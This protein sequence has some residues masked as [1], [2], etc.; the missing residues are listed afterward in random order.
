MILSAVHGGLFALTLIFT[1]P[2]PK[3]G[4][5]E[6]VYAVGSS[7]VAPLPPPPPPVSPS[8]IARGSWR[9][10]GWLAV[11]LH[12]T[13]PVAGMSPARPSLISLG[14]G[15]E[16]GWRIRQWLALGAAFGRQP[17]ELYR[18]YDPELLATFSYRGFMSA[19]DVAFVRVY[20]PIRGRF[21]PYID[22][23]GGLSFFNPARDR[24]NE[25]GATV[26]AGAGFDIWVSRTMT[27]GA[28]GI[29]RVNFIDTTVGQ[30]WQAALNIGL[31]W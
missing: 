10:I 23:G 6:G 28:S 19:L 30:A 9:G 8:T 12:G 14:G 16:G 27:L 22:V 18:E 20:A 29:Y 26:R 11:S 4:P 13:G 15:V 5:S 1:P 7:G 24:P 2:N 25:I 3:A 31:H 21:D 17:H